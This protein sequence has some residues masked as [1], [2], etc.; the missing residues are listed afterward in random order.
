MLA[1]IHRN[2]SGREGRRS[3]GFTLVE[4]LVSLTV[5]TVIVGAALLVMH[6]STRTKEVGS[7]L[8]EAQQNARFA[9]NAILGD[10]RSA[11]YGID[12]GVEAP[13]EVA[14]DFRLTLRIDRDRD[15]V[16]DDGER[17]T[18]FVDA[19]QGQDLANRSANPYDYV[20]RRVVNSAVDSLAAP[21]PGAG[22][23][24]AYLV[25][26][27]SSNAL[28]SRDVPLFR[29]F[30]EAGAELVGNAPDPAGTDFGYTVSDS[31]LGLPAGSGL[32]LELA[33]IQVR[34]ITETSSPRRGTTDDYRRFDLGA[35]VRPRNFAFEF[36]GTFAVY[37]S[38]GGAPGDST[39][40]PPDSTGA[41]PDSTVEPPLPPW[42]PPIRISTARVL[43]M[44]LR[45]LNELDSQEG[46]ATTVD[47]QLDW[48]IVLGTKASAVNNLSVWFNG[49]PGLYDGERLY[50]SNPNFYGNSPYDLTDLAIANLD[51]SPFADADVAAAVR[52]SDT[53][54]GF[55]VWRN[56][57]FANQGMVGYG[58]PTTAPDAYY[59]ASGQGLTIAV[60]D[61]DGDGDRD[62]ILG[63]RTGAN[64][65]DVELWRNVGGTFQAWDR[66]GAFGEVH[67]IAIVDYN[68]DGL[69]DVIA[70]TKTATTDKAGQIVLFKNN[71][72]GIA[73]VVRYDSGGKVTAL[74]AG[75]LDRDGIT[76]VVA[77]TK[78]GNN[79]GAIEYWR[80]TGAGFVKAETSVADGPV[81]CVAVGSLDYGNTDPDIAA[82]NEKNTVQAWFV[83]PSNTGNIVPDMES[84]A[85]ANAG[86]KVHAVQIGK[87]EVPPS[88]AWADPLGD[89]VIG[90][91]VSATTGEIVIYLNPF[92]WTINP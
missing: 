44:A 2:E 86:G 36:A 81:L 22:D 30:D 40:G 63:T 18:Y 26:Q 62:V 85:D 65:G 33:R 52:I 57:S 79:T 67:A 61:M 3:P 91:E 84:W 25:T 16:M 17:I 87:I 12:E 56:Q 32:E 74:A 1:S 38:S 70:G 48:D 51:W 78:T 31:A 19:D 34:V 29:Y 64:T 58:Y 10:L 45:N 15:G 39:G 72:N 66:D 53:A 60:A 11:G 13:I 20:L 9:L 92:V 49:Q 73:H 4:L 37:D 54:G 90:T 77:G 71:G 41:P 46:S 76:D 89:I 27:R 55:Q 7:N 83:D 80:G 23:V 69:R 5:V 75:D 43:S 42:E 59:T 24:V 88:M 6:G 21:A 35:S 8:A 68:G 47:N 50:R 28:K 14:S 82:G